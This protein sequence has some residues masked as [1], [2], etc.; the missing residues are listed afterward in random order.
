MTIPNIPKGFKFS[1]ASSGIKK[2]ERK[3]IGLIFSEVESNIAGL[4][5]TNKVKAAPVRLA[6]EKI[7]SHRGQAI[8][9]NSGNANACTGGKGMEDAV[10][11]A[12]LTA[13]K[14]GIKPELVY[15]ASTGV[16]G[17]PMHMERLRRGLVEAVSGL[18]NGCIEDVAMAIMTTDTFP[19][20]V[21]REVNIDGGNGVI[22]GIAKGAG[23]I[24]PDMATMLSFIMT[25]ISISAQAIDLA[26]RESVSKSFN[27]LTVDGDRSTNDTVLLIANGTLGNNELSIDS[28]E[29]ASFKRTLDDITHELSRLI[30]KDGEGATKLIEVVVVGARNEDDAKRAAFA[31]ANSNLVKTAIYGN[32]ANWGRIMAAV[33]YSGA[34]IID[35]MVSIFFNDLKVVEKGLTLR[36]DKEAAEILK[37]K[38]IRITVDLG[39][40]N[41]ETKVLSCDLT[42]EYIRINAAY[43]S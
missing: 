16:I 29:F 39:L 14:L 13:E 2:S 1:S 27:R 8:I 37:D 24:C 26:L 35:D 12:N 31:V 23:M 22:T 5:T 33:G 18:G 6:L 36:K 19:K 30:A 34:D 40:G 17:E 28:K 21:S 9:A 32:D 7:I 4:F 42:E 43:R 3:D 38:E 15:V 25:D 41:A 20:I 10:E 11:M